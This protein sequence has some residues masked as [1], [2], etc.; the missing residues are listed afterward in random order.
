MKNH[1]ETP[2]KTPTDAQVLGQDFGRIRS[3]IF[4]GDQQPTTEMMG[5][6]TTSLSVAINN[7]LKEIGSDRERVNTFF[8]EFPPCDASATDAL[9]Q[10]MTERW[11]KSSDLPI[12]ECYTLIQNPNTRLALGLVPIPAVVT[13]SKISTASDEELGR[14]LTLYA[15]QMMEIFKSNKS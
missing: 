12:E 8:K 7:R 11:A 9:A 1:L 14:N 3:N 6:Y 10:V 13:I 4:Q 15:S 2:A 5:Q